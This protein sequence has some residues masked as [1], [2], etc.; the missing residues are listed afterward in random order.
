MS[1]Q[2][3][4]DSN[5]PV[6][7]FSRGEIGNLYGVISSVAG[8]PLFLDGQVYRHSP[9]ASELLEIASASGIVES[10]L[11]SRYKARSLQFKMQSLIDASQRSAYIELHSNV[12]AD[13]FLAML[14]QDSEDLLYGAAH[15]IVVTY[16][17]V[18]TP[19]THDSVT[20]Q[21][22]AYIRTHPDLLEPTAINSLEAQNPHF[23][24]VVGQ[25]I[26]EL[27][28]GPL[29]NGANLKQVRRTYPETTDMINRVLGED[30]IRAESIVAQGNKLDTR[31][32]SLIL[33]LARTS[34]SLDEQ[35]VRQIRR[36]IEEEFPRKE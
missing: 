7:P 28:S 12:G 30:L 4:V 31:Q 36:I 34:T 18:F 15:R 16:P 3:R 10:T 19:E 13:L 17:Y 23:R 9:I 8:T 14:C 24:S 20:G 25:V 27:L 26:G 33:I 29:A 2:E 22:E 32:L 1:V 6:K 21:L 35:F 11:T 5:R